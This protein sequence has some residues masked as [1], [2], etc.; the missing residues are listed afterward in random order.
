MPAPQSKANKP[1]EASSA[2]AADATDHSVVA[3]VATSP[4]E[5]VAEVVAVVVA[6]VVVATTAATSTQMT[7]SVIMDYGTLALAASTALSILM[8]LVPLA[9]T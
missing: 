8:L 2:G 5:V 1:T 7:G 4:T 6:A 9:T 3:A